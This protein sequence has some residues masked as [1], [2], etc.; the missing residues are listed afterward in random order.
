MLLWWIVIMFWFLFCASTINLCY[1]SLL[2]F[3]AA[4]L[5][6]ELHAWEYFFVLS[7]FFLDPMLTKLKCFTFFLFAFFKPIYNALYSCTSF[8]EISKYSAF[9]MTAHVISDIKLSLVYK[10]WTMFHYNYFCDFVLIMG[11]KFSEVNS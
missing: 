5:Q 11:L 2:Y 10:F 8:A 6:S 3:V 4:F 7:I 1:S 9:W